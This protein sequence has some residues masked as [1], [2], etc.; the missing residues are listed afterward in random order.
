MVQVLGV[1]RVVHLLAGV[2]GARR[3]AATRATVLMVA[4]GRVAVTA[5][6]AATTLVTRW[7]RAS[8]TGGTGRAAATCTA[9][10]HIESVISDVRRVEERRI[11]VLIFLILT[12]SKVSRLISDPHIFEYVNE[13][14][15]FIFVGGVQSVLAVDLHFDS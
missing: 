15:V 1:C 12:R 11:L 8:A 5:S 13:T 7:E 6:A 3:V 2:V 10:W 9:P 4:A 14:L